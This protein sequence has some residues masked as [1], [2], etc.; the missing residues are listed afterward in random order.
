MCVERFKIFSTARDDINYKARAMSHFMSRHFM[1]IVHD[2]RDE[3]CVV[4]GG[5]GRTKMYNMVE[6]MVLPQGGSLERDQ[7]TSPNQFSKYSFQRYMAGMK[8]KV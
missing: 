7:V 1:Y 4:E 8:V 5:R 3:V 6:R 2:T